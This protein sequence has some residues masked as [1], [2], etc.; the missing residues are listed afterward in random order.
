M[1]KFKEWAFRKPWV[2]IFSAC[3]VIWAAVAAAIAWA[4]LP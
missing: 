3:A 2:A 4:V 1:K